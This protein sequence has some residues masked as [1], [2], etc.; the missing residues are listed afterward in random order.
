MILPIINI[1]LD[2]VG[3]K[4]N[5]SD[6]LIKLTGIFDTGAFMDIFVR[7]MYVCMHLDAH[8][9]F[10]MAMWTF[11]DTSSKTQVR[12]RAKSYIRD[13]LSNIVITPGK[14]NYHNEFAYLA[15]IK[16]EKVFKI[17]YYLPLDNTV[18]MWM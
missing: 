15:R 12:S 14:Y 6:E 13:L 17:K 9:M 16:P 8:V 7:S 18:N 4:I 10:N 11:I 3:N 5:T 1:I 2:Y